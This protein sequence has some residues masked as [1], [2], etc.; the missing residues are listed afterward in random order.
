MISYLII[1]SFNLNEVC[2][3]FTFSALRIDKFYINGI[4]FLK[5]IQ[6]LDESFYTQQVDT[7]IN[8]H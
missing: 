7:F 6:M 5:K 1:L 8:S 4:I 2:L 3:K